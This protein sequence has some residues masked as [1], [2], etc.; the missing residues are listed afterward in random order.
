MTVDLRDVEEFLALGRIAVIG[1]SDDP[2][3]FARTVYVQLRDHGHDVVAVHPTATTVAGDPCWPSL[4]DLPDP[5]DGALIMV[6]AVKAAAV[7]RDCAD[8]RIDHIWLFRGLGGDGAVSDEVLE[9]CEER[10]LAVV[11]GACPL[12]FLEPVG[13]FHRLHRGA[14]RARRDLVATGAPG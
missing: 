3:S 14:R 6:T 11:A 13:W 10:N 1:V 9:V 4:D 5:V 12:M 2:K 8:H 7:V